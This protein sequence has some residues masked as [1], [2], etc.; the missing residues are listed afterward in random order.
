[1]SG[2]YSIYMLQPSGYKNTTH[3]ICFLVEKTLT[4]LV[5]VLEA[6]TSFE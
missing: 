6:L 2:N 3:F 4:Q 5:D 1:M